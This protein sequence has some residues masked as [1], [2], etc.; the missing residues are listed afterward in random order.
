MKKKFLAMVLIASMVFSFTGCSKGKDEVEKDVSTAN[1]V[2]EETN[3]DADSDTASEDSSALITEDVTINVRAM[4]QYTNL[5]RI[6]DKYYELVADDPNLKHVKLNFSYVPGADYKDKLTTAVVAQE[7][8]DLLFVGSWQGRTDFIKDGVFKDVSKYF[9]DSKSYPG[10]SKVFPE[11]MVEAQK[12]N[13]GLYYVPL[14]AGEDLRGVI[15]REDLR[16]KYGCDEIVDDNT[17]MAYLQTIQSHIDD[18]SLDMKYAWG[19]TGQ[20]F[21]TFRDMMFEAQK[22]N[23]LKVNVANG[24][25]FFV[26]VDD[27]NKVVNA[28]VIGDDASQFAGFPTGYDK[29]F[30]AEH[31]ADLTNYVQYAN[32]YAIDGDQY[33]DF[34]MGQVAVAYKSF[35]EQG[36]AIKELKKNVPDAETKFYVFDEDQRNMVSGGIPSTLAANNSVAIPAW[37]S[38][39][40]TTAVMCFLDAL[41]SNKEIN[42]LFIYGVEG[43]DWESKDGVVLNTLKDSEDPDYYSFP[44]YSLIYT[45]Q[46]MGYYQDW[47]ANDEAL[48]KYY[49]YQSDLENSYTLTKFVGFSFDATNI[50]SEKAAITGVAE[51]YMFNYGTYETADATYE[52][53]A[54]QHK[55]LEDAGLE[56][57]RQEVIKQVQAFF[58]AK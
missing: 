41:Y 8:I 38:E 56:T 21:M 27:N 6:L 54:E 2:A 34:N 25:D 53:I 42:D 23:M 35:S 13:G 46:G 48:K 30:I 47:V 16:K 5:D 1:E 31:Y 7:D 28:T 29:D 55:Q 50:E 37:S 49:D 33:I 40:K 20:G 24:L 58:D 18:G 3:T 39:E 10:L 43:E 9:T 51:N 11:K 52:K 12:Y 36:A 57:V 26:Y 14:G 44:S 4:N 19:I 22:N 32:N 17:L 45:P 15:Y